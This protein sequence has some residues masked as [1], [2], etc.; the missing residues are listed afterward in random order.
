MTTPPRAKTAE[1]IV[2]EWFGG[3]R[4]EDLGDGQALVEMLDQALKQ[5]RAAAIEECA[6]LCEESPYTLSSSEHPDV[7]RTVHTTLVDRA[8]QIRA[9]LSSEAGGTRG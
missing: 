5:A 9:L 1:E 3:A 8:W 7:Q 6:K 4:I 2:R